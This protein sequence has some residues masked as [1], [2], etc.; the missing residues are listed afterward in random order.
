MRSDDQV[1]Y[2]ETG[3]FEVALEHP[4][5]REDGLPARRDVNG[6]ANRGPAENMV[7]ATSDVWMWEQTPKE[8]RHVLCDGVGRLRSEH[9][10]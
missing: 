8:H 7:D 5:R 6:G 2:R 10:M 9:D 3:L 4:D 1:L